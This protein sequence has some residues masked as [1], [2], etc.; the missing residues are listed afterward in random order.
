MATGYDEGR[1]WLKVLSQAF[2]KSKKRGTPEFSLRVL[3]KGRV[4]PEAPDGDLLSCAQN[5]RT[6]Y[7]YIT[8]NTAE[9]VL[10]DLER[11]GF[12]KSSFRFLDPQ[13]NGF[14]NF[15]DAEFEGFCDHEEYEGKVNE[16]W[17]FAKPRGQQDVTPLEDGE[18]RKLDAL[19]GKQL[20][21][22]A[23]RKPEKPA[24]KPA[25]KAATAVIDRPPPPDDDSI[26][27]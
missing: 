23:A 6:I 11:I 9:Y 13:A 17:R 7:L 1:Y 20:Q 15:A 14:H 16:K 27:F 4:N 3:V 10:R 24:D 22:V 8:E 25:E 19:F 12:D 21:K 26:P 18:V 5:E 2:G